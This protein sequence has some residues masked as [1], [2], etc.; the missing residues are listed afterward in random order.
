MPREEKLFLI[1]GGIATII[2]L[3]LVAYSWISR[4][5]AA[6][7]HAPQTLTDQQKA[8]LFRSVQ[9]ASSSSLTKQQEADLFRPASAASSSS[10][11]SSSTTAVKKPASSAKPA[12]VTPQQQSNLFRSVKA[13]QNTGTKLTPQQQSDLFKSVK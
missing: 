7:S 9:S 6:N 8:D 2:V 12:T 13:N 1:L 4:M 5:N 11:S 3:S 10:I